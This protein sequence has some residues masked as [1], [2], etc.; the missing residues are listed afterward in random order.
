MSAT[1]PGRT[2]QAGHQRDVNEHVPVG[3]CLDVL[4]L[5]SEAATHGGRSASS[6]S[7]TPAR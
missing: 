5:G 2:H 3:S 4:R 1:I 7:V 6:L